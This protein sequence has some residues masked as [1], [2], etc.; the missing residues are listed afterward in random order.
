MSMV[1][2][3]GFWSNKAKNEKNVEVPVTKTPAAAPANTDK[4]TASPVSTNAIAGIKK[5]IAIASGKGG[6]GKST[7]AVNLAKA[8]EM[9]GNRVGLLD[10]DIHGPSLPLMLSTTNPTE[11]ND[12]LLVPP[13][14]ENMKVISSAMFSS[15]G[16]HIMRGPMAANFI[17]QLL[18]QVDWGDLDFLII[19]YPPGTG[20]IQLTLSQ[21]CNITAAV[22]VSSPQDIALTDV[23]KACQMFETLKVPILGVIETMSWFQC[24]QCDKKHFIFKKDGGRQLAQQL[25]VPL[26]AQIPLDP[27]ITEHG[28]SGK[29]FVSQV[30]KSPAALAF[31]QAADSSLAELKILQEQTQNGLVS[32][33]LKWQ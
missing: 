16:A 1:I 10:A 6:V 7:V 15:Q 21:V 3:M 4:L 14:S 20:D 33:S 22:I 5:I 26:L 11:M 8:L 32:F 13:I 19:D 12:K 28:D 30:T 29:S 9:R 18:T 24:D 2:K 23:R 17:R 31:S 25:G 27:A